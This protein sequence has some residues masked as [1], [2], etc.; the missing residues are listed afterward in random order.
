MFFIRSALADALEGLDDE[1]RQLIQEINSLRR[2]MLAVRRA[3][4]SRELDGMSAGPVSTPCD[5]CDS[6]IPTGALVCRFC[7]RPVFANREQYAEI[8]G[9]IEARIASMGRE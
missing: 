6:Q 4:L 2:E 8:A 9:F 3:V 7:R 1:E 5:Y